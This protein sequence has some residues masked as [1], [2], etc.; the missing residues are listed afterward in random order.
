MKSQHTLLDLSVLPPHARNQLVGL[1]EFMRREYGKGPTP[2]SFKKKGGAFSAFLA[3][4]VEVEKVTRFGR[5]E[6]H[7]RE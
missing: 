7:E 4:P 6:L 2:P 1:Y 5:D 3:E